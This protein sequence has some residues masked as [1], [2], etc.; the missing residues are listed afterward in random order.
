VKRRL[1]GADIFGRIA[2][3]KPFLS[4]QNKRKRLQWAKIINIG[5]F[6]NGKN[7]LDR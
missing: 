4:I 7:P 1:N 3:K 5:Q 6:G 2:N